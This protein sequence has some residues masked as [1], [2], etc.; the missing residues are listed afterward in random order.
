MPRRPR[1]G[2]PAF[3]PTPARNDIVRAPMKSIRTGSVLFVWLLALAAC[4]GGKKPAD[5]PENAD[6]SAS[7]ES[8][9]EDGGAGAMGGDNTPPGDTTPPAAGGA[10]PGDDKS[11]KSSPCGGFAIEDLSSVLSQAACEVE[12]PNPNEQ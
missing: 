1:P 11:K 5:S 4:G 10:A 3:S 8:S 7:S 9:S 6:E 2:R 12:N